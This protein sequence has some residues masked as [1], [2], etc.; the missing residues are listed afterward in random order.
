MNIAQL[1]MFWKIP[2]HDTYGSN[3]SADIL[4][5][6]PTEF[7]NKFDLKKERKCKSSI[8][9]TIRLKHNIHL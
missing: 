9:Q 5:L 4:L 8:L 3:I 1:A 6:I 7:P 2:Q